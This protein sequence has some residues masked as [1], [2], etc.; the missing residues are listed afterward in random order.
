PRPKVTRLCAVESGF[1]A[2]VQSRSAAE[3]NRS[4]RRSR[5]AAILGSLAQPATKLSN[6]VTED[7]NV[8][9]AATLSSG[10]ASIGKINSQVN[11]RGLFVSLTRATV[12]APESFAREAASMRSSLRPD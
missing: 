11:A 5:A 10:P 4:G 12:M 6:A 1:R 7:T 2:W 3:A 8:L 9:V